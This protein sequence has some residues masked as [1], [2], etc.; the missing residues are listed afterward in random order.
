MK[1]MLIPKRKKE[2]NRAHRN[3]AAFFRANINFNAVVL[4]NST[5]EHYLEPSNLITFNTDC[6]SM[7][8]AI[9]ADCGH[10]AGINRTQLHGKCAQYLQIPLCPSS[11][12]FRFPFIILRERKHVESMR[13]GE[14]QR[15][16]EEQTP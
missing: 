1:A 10:Q 6:P 7:R 11:V 4:L 14:G 16:K 9:L 8:Q 5:G 3:K 13:R 15:E 2:E 12:L